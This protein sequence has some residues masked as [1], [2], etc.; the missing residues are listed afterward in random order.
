MESVFLEPMS[1]ASLLRLFN[2]RK[3]LLIQL[4]M[5]CR[6]GVKSGGGFGGYITLGIIGVAV[7]L[8]TMVTEDFTQGEEVGDE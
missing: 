1:R 7:K 6:Q 4:L 5:S 3:F 2:F 8:D